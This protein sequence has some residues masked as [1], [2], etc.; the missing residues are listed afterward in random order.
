[1]AA[2]C[3]YTDIEAQILGTGFTA[4]TTMTEAALTELC[5]QEASVMDAYLAGVWTVPMTDVTAVAA[6]KSVNQLLA[7][8]RALEILFG[9]RA[10]E[11]HPLVVYWREQAMERLREYVKIGPDAFPS[12]AVKATSDDQVSAPLADY[13]TGENVEP[14]M[15]VREDGSGGDEHT[16][17]VW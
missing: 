9:A 14:T 7:A 16:G 13:S 11:V 15:T 6:L 2:Y 4:A 17:R 10:P 1:M 8:A 3:L 5:T 12:A